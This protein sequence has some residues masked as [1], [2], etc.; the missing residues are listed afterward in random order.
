MGSNMAFSIDIDAPLSGRS[1]KATI[2]V[3]NEQGQIAYT[4]HDD[5][6]D[7]AGRR[8]VAKDLAKRLGEP[9]DD[10]EQR[11]HESW[12]AALNRHE[13]EPAEPESL[14]ELA[15]C[16]QDDEGSLCLV[17]GD[18]VVPLCNFTGRI[19]EETVHDDGSGEQKYFFLVE[20]RLACG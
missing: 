4:Y 15:P 7:R 3:R 11:L 14:P 12:V 16:Y 6:R 9:V 20:G 13:Q 1:R 19:V 5:L 2:I 17:R 18:A 10:L 8:R